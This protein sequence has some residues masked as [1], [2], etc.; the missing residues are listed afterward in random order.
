[1]NSLLRLGALL[2]VLAA[3]AFAA[4]DSYGGKA[5]GAAP[6][7]TFSWPLDGAT[8]QP[9]GGT[10]KGAPLTLDTEPSNEWKALQ[11]PGISAFERDRR[12]ILAMAGTYRVTFDFLEVVPYATL[13]KPNAPYQSWGTEKIYVDADEGKFISLVH[14]LEM[15]FVQQDGTISEPMVTKHWRQD[16]R[17][18][19]QFIVEHKGRDRW[20]R[21]TLAAE[22]RRNAW[23]QTVYQVDES[24]RYASAG[25]WQHSASFST[26]LSGETWRPLPRR[27]WSV[28]DDYQVLVGTNRHT[29][30]PAGWVQ[31]ENNLKTVLTNG[32]S[33]DATRPYIAREYGVAR[34][35]RIRDAD[36]AAADR[37][38][39]RT[40][41]FWDQV[42]DSWSQVF[43]TQGTATLKGPVDKLGLFKPLFARADEIEATGTSEPA[44]NQQIIR[45][46][47]GE[48]G[49][50]VK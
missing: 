31:E 7:Y 39:E 19:P 43:A 38:F 3:P 26:W 41:L 6:R 20:D 48:M 44:A 13:G 5:T 37:Y 12:A 35:E 40:K 22:E 34:Y 24:P 36:F 46:A 21:R 49:V 1:M 42:R 8:L 29:I 50:T 2:C 23:T 14:I 16:W 32:R 10:T 45:D 25:R 4:E 15:R 33:I 18:E 17:Y 9:R 28:R 30:A 27:E 47:L 11:A